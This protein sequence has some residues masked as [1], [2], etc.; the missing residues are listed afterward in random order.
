[1]VE[2]VKL[3]W[4]RLPIS[5]STDTYPGLYGI[6]GNT[7][8]VLVCQ[9]QRIFEAAWEAPG[10]PHFEK[11][12]AEKHGLPGYWEELAG[13]RYSA[14]QVSHWAPVPNLDPE[15]AA[16]CQFDQTRLDLGWE[17]LNPQEENQVVLIRTLNWVQARYR[18][19]HRTWVDVFGRVTI[20]PLR[21][22]ILVELPD[23]LLS[24][25]ARISGPTNPLWR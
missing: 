12:Y 9:N 19:E 23:D 6:V 15:R 17:K 24:G 7:E 25:N 21:T 1:M 3:D 16:S 4:Q 22:G 13:N 2:V 11:A 20:S 10:H 8:T 5:P 14:G 18:P